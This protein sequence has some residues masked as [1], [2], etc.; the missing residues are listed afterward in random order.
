MNLFAKSEGEEGW[1]NSNWLWRVRG[2]L[3]R[4]FLGVGT[5]RGR[6]NLPNLAINDVIDFWRIEDLRKD[7]KLLLR[8]EMKIPGRAWLEFNIDEQE[9][10]RKL[11][12]IA[13]YDTD[14]MI[15]RIYWS[16]CLPFHHFI[17]N[18]LLKGIEQRS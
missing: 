8:A 15:G 14:T 17:F 16:L 9:S 18:D 3:D 13:Y 2:L 4:L 11:S 1:F 10:R 5:S 6:K 7:K 12:V